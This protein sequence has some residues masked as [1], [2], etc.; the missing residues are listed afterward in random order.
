L[1]WRKSKSEEDKVRYKKLKQQC[2]KIIAHAKKEKSHEM[3]ESLGSAEGK[4]NVWRI[5]KQ[6]VKQRQ[7][8]VKV[9]CLKSEDCNVVMDDE[10]VK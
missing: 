7:D 2:K 9:N 6:M 3:A 5:A 8:V 10:E 4:K 1:L